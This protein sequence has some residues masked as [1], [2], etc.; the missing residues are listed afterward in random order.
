MSSKLN[1]KLRSKRSHKDREG[2]LQ[3]FLRS[4]S[5]YRLAHMTKRAAAEESK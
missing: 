4:A 5:Y 2:K 3:D 1:H